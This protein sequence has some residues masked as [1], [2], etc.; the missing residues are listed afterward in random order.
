MYLLDYVFLYI[1][2]VLFVLLKASDKQDVKFLNLNVKRVWYLILKKK[3]L[4]ILDYVFTLSDIYAFW[5]IGITEDKWT[6]F[7]FELKT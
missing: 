4:L 6:T 7:Y 1:I 3:E 2:C 5:V